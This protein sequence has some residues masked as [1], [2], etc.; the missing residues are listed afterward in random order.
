MTLKEMREMARKAFEQNHKGKP[1]EDLTKIANAGSEHDPRK[2]PKE[3][4]EDEED[5]T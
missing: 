1:I 3:V 2:L 4:K 5:P